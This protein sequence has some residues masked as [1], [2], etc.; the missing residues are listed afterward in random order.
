MAYDYGAP[1]GL[2]DS[3]KAYYSGMAEG[4]PE[5]A[6]AMM[7]EDGREENGRFDGRP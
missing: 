3:E 7:S 2:P 1:S 4:V 6:T 5:A